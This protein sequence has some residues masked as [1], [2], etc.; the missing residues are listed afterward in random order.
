MFTEQWLYFR[1]FLAVYFDLKKCFRIYQILASN[2]G[3]DSSSFCRIHNY[4]LKVRDP[5]TRAALLCGVTDPAIN[6]RPSTLHSRTATGL[7]ASV[8]LSA[9]LSGFAVVMPGNRALA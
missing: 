9:S 5:T 2:F 8:I 4:V 1:N 7:Q 6:S 3:R